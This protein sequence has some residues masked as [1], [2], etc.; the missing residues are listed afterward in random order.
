MSEKILIEMTITAKIPSG[1]DL[2]E[3]TTSPLNKYEIELPNPQPGQKLKPIFAIGH[4]VKCVS[5]GE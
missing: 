4:I 2:N 5:P 3:E 1:C